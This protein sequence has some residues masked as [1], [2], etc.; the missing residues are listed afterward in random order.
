MAHL[1]PY[2]D[3]D[4]GQQRVRPRSPANRIAVTERLLSRDRSTVEGQ[5]VHALVGDPPAA[6]AERESRVLPGHRGHIRK[7]QLNGPAPGTGA[8]HQ[9]RRD[10][11]A[12][13]QPQHRD[14]S[15]APFH[16]RRLAVGDRRARAGFLPNVAAGPGVRRLPG[17]IRELRRGVR[18]LGI[19]Q[20][21]L[22]ADGHR[23][24]LAQAVAAQWNRYVGDDVHVRPVR[25]GEARSV[26]SDLLF[27][28]LGHARADHTGFHP[29][30]H[31]PEIIGMQLQF[32]NARREQRPVRRDHERVGQVPHRDLQHVLSVAPRPGGY[33]SY[34]RMIS[35]DAQGPQAGHARG[36]KCRDDHQY[37]RSG[38]H[39]TG[40][41][42]QGHP[43]CRRAARQNPASAPSPQRSAG[44]PACCFPAFR[45]RHRP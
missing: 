7:H 18:V 38:D 36:T 19:R 34:P 33:L 37:H 23:M 30:T 43:A 39:R 14:G 2:A 44:R 21:R 25:P 13:D 26:R 15:E 17:G 16:D 10:R 8:G 4:P 35:R 3:L 42:N 41:D 45:H 5:P 22:G 1:V 32:D 31:R 24:A 11:G 40:H 28:S 6:V 9:G 27:V 29:L 12:R 20:V